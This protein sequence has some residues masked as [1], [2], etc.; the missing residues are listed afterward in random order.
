[1]GAFHG[2]GYSGL[3]PSRIADV[4]D[5]LS[6]TLF[7][8]ERHTKSHT[9]RGP[10]WAN[11]FNLYTTGAAQPLWASA[12]LADYD[13]CSTQCPN[14]NFCKYGWG[15]LHTGGIIQFVFGDGSVHPINQNINLNIFCALATIAGSENPDM[16]Q[17]Y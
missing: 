12:L 6:N 9:T 10:F 14:A 4:L 5:G 16:N 7:V 11:S 1:M 15:S 3:K 13:L 2:D 8:G 17:A